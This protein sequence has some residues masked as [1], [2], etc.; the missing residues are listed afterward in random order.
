MKY[1]DDLI[2]EKD[3]QTIEI[4]KVCIMNSIQES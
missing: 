4:A 3:S 1:F 2:E